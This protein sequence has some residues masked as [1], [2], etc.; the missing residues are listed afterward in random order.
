MRKSLLT[1]L[2]LGCGA[3]L[4]LVSFGAGAI[5]IHVGLVGAGGNSSWT[6]PSF[7]DPSTLTLSGWEYDSGQWASAVMNYKCTNSSGHRENNG[8]C[9]NLPTTGVET[10]VGVVCKG[11]Q[12]AVCKQDEIG[13]TPWQ[14]IDVNIFGLKNWASFTINLGSVNEAG[15]GG[16][17]TGYLLGAKCSRGDITCTATPILEDSC[18]YGGPGKSQVCSFTFNPL[19]LSGITDIWVASSLTD[20]SCGDVKPCNDANILLGGDFAFSNVPEP[21]ALGIFGLGL[22]LIGAFVGLRRR[23]YRTA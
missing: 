12:T 19:Q 18:T 14:M 16:S 7:G 21:K 8:A 22:L 15:T 20:Q 4:G 6:S 5:P 23:R 11:T 10:G 17:E 9:A 13:A 1:S 3:L 2:A